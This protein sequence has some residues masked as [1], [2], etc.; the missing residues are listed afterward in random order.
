[1]EKEIWK[2]FEKRGFKRVLMWR[3][4]CFTLQKIAKN[5]KVLEIRKVFRSGNMVESKMILK[6]NTPST[7]CGTS[8]QSSVLKVRITLLTTVSIV[9]LPS[10][11]VKKGYFWKKEKK[12]KLKK[13]FPEKTKKIW[14]VSNSKKRL[15]SNLIATAF[16]LTRGR[17]GQCDRTR[18]QIIACLILSIF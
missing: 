11:E 10:G 18:A 4:F 7:T 12:K 2:F 8:L 1:L 16:Y 14:A 15:Y 6:I 17:Y 3:I 9:C 13:K 5:N